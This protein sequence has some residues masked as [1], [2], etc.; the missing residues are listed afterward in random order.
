[1]GSA[2]IRDFRMWHGKLESLS[3]GSCDDKAVLS[4]PLL[5]QVVG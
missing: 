4:R 5:K 1:M 3:N 2:M